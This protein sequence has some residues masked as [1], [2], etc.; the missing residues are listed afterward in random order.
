MRKLFSKLPNKIQLC[1]PVIETLINMQGVEQVVDELIV[2]YLQNKKI[3]KEL[4]TFLFFAYLGIE[5]CQ[6]TPIFIPTNRKNWHVV[7]VLKSIFSSFNFT[8]QYKLCNDVKDM[9][10][11]RND[12][13]AT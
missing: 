12:H 1:F 8:Q 2:M 9:A 4:A 10:N 7:D 6:E 3:N 11:I 5:F 13:K